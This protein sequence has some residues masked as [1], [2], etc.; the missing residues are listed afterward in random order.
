MN[1]G[2]EF[3]QFQAKKDLGPC[4]VQPYYFT[5]EDQRQASVP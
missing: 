1:D 4:L 5:D 3:E 2:W